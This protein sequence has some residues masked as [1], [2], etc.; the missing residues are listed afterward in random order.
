LRLASYF[1]G[2]AAVC[3]VVASIATAGGVD[4][5][6]ATEAAGV[7]WGVQALVS[8]PLLRSLGARR[9]A[10]RPWIAGMAARVAAL[11][12]AMVL[13]GAD[14]VSRDAGIVFG[15]SLTALI[16]TEAVW[17]AAVPASGGPRD[18]TRE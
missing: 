9:N 6:S 17:L 16:I 8:F 2:A 3:L 11:L 13:V 12:V 10:N 14:V 1:A 5:R 18:K 4:G 7:A 15:L